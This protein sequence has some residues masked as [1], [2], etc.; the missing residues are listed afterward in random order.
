MLNIIHLIQN[1][2]NT[3]PLGEFAGRGIGRGGDEH[4]T[5]YKRPTE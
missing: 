5:R 3:A 1:D 2:L 4:E